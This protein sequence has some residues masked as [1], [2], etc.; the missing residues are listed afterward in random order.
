MVGFVKVPFPY[1]EGA[2]ITAIAE[3]FAKPW[4]ASETFNGAK[5]TMRF[6]PVSLTKRVPSAAAASP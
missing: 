4:D 1:K 2:P 5:M 3:R 6:F